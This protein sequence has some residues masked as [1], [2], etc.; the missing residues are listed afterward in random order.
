[1]RN[2]GF[3]LIELVL[4]VALLGVLAI[5]AF[6]IFFNS[7]LTSARSSS[8]NATVGA[9]QSGIAL[10]AATEA[11]AGND[12]T[13]PTTLDDAADNSTAS[14]TT[15]FFGTVLQN[16]VTSQWFKVSSTCYAYDTD[17]DGTRDAN[18][19]DTYFLY[20]SADGTFTQTAGCS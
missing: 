14:S 17:G 3:T 2:S 15:P 20:T 16:A 11:A 12:L 18:P 5:T 9:I 6:P 4:V 7:T 13:Y 1:M 10:Y 8:M 19:T